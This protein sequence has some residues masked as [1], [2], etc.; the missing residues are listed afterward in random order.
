MSVSQQELAS[1][2]DVPIPVTLDNYYEYM[3]VCLE[4]AGID[5][6]EFDRDQTAHRFATLTGCP[7]QE[8]IGYLSTESV[9]ELNS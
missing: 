8:I 7:V 1:S 6:N 5:C 4:Y 3:R 2:R 9:L